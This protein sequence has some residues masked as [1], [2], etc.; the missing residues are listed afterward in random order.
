MFSEGNWS[1][2]I[3]QALEVLLNQMNNEWINVKIL[4]TGVG[5]ISTSEVEMAAI[6]NAVVVGFNVE[7]QPQAQKIIREKDVV[8]VHGPVIYDILDRLKVEYTVIY[9]SF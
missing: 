8:S 7:P 2:S 6:T 1:I 4:N 5:P 9:T 3:S